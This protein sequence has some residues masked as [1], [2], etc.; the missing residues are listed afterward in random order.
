MAVPAPPAHSPGGQRRNRWKTQ[1][2]PASPA[3]PTGFPARARAR[4]TLF[5]GKAP[6]LVV[7]RTVSQKLNHSVGLV[8]LVGL[9]GERGLHPTS[10]SP[11]TPGD[12]PATLSALLSALRA[13]GLWV[14]V[15]GDRSKIR[16]GAVTDAL[17]AALAEHRP[18]LLR[19]ARGGPGTWRQ[20]LDR[21]DDDT[22]E[23][24][25]LLAA[26]YEAQGL[27]PRAAEFL[28]WETLA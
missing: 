19:L 26:G 24:W 18:H 23:A 8:G 21:A 13:A 7:C 12:S 1:G 28:A 27:H 6:C 9:K 25:A 15:D 4:T 3:S 11:A 10:G 16:G 17:R 14:E 2:S 5:S 22:R 20:A